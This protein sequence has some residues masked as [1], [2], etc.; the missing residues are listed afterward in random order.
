MASRLARP[1]AHRR[2][3]RTPSGA[4][5]GIGM[6]ASWGKPMRD[7]SMASTRHGGGGSTGA[8]AGERV[9]EE[10]ARAYRVSTKDT[11]RARLQQRRHARAR[12]ARKC[13][14]HAAL[15][16]AIECSPGPSTRPRPRR[17]AVADTHLLAQ[18]H[19]HHAR[20]HQIVEAERPARVGLPRLDLRGR[21]RGK[22]LQQRLHLL[23]VRLEV[24]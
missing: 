8:R 23:L 20:R 9:A 19:E 13:D 12:P 16:R 7:S 21:L 2:A 14:A 24:A 1:A 17:R 10:H 3:C 4:R 15:R 6:R 11:P 5:R 22:L 18:R